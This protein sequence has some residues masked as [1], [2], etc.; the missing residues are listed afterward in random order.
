VF[1]MQMEPLAQSIYT[2]R[3]QFMDELIPVFNDY[4]TRISN[5]NENVSLTYTSQLHET[6]FKNGVVQSSGKDRALQYTTFG[7]HKDDL[8]FLLDGYSLKKMASQGQQKTFLLALKL[9]QFG[10]LEHVN[11][12]KPILLLDDIF[13]KF[14]SGRVKQLLH[15]VSADTFGQLF[16][17]H[18]HA[19]RMQQILEEIKLGGKLFMIDSNGAE[20]KELEYE[21]K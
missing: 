6:D 5:K 1:D 12:S 18:T 19:E 4:Y 10:I 21:K 14:D 13:D 8:D 9:A 2:K 20:I 17:T 16:I 15:L 7:I 3:K 11:H